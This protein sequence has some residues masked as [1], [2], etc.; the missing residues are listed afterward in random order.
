MLHLVQLSSQSL[1]L[2]IDIEAIMLALTVLVAPD[3]A[4]AVAENEV[5]RHNRRMQIVAVQVLK[6]VS[7]LCLDRARLGAPHFQ[8]HLC[9]E[10]PGTEWPITTISFDSHHWLIRI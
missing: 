10:W 9:I 2:H 7:G 1:K 5:R 3:N 8:I 6:N 4:I